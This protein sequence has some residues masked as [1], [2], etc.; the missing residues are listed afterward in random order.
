MQDTKKNEK[1]KIEELKVEIAENKK[2]FRATNEE[3]KQRDNELTELKT[4]IMQLKKSRAEND[5][6]LQKATKDFDRFQSSNKDNTE[7][8]NTLK[9]DLRRAE[10][11]YH[12]LLRQKESMAKKA[13]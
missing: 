8:Q 3:Y 5:K 1:Q 10:V 4:N 11:E 13:A 2:E 9:E 12:K 6:I 7:Q